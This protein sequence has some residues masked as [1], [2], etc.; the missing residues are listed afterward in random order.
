MKKIVLL[1]AAIT[2]LTACSSADTPTTPRDENQ[3][4]DGI[5]IPVEGTGAIAGGSFMPE[6]EQQSMPDSMK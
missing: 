6:I 5:M 4:A 1:L 2:T 3:L